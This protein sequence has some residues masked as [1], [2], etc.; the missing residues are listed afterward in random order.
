MLHNEFETINERRHL[1]MNNEVFIGAI[2]AGGSKIV[3]TVGR[4]W[5]EICDSEKY[6]VPTTTPDE[7][8]TRVLDWFEIRNREHTINAFGVATFGPVDFAT[9]SIGMTTPKKAWRGFSWQN[10]IDERFPALPIGY[11]TDTNAAGIAEWRWGI[12]KDRRVV[13]YVTVGTGIGG[14]L[15]IDG[16]PVHG[17]L[18]P[19]FGHMFVPRQDGDEFVGTCPA[20]GH[21][22]EG[23]ASG[24]AVNRRRQQNDSMNRWTISQWDLES[25]YLSLAMANVISVA[26]PEI[27]ILG[28][29]IMNVERL[30][31]KV[32][33][34][35]KELLSGYI[36]KEELG[37]RI[38]EYL[39]SPALGA[40]SGVVGAFALGFDAIH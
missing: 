21:C 8:I 9:K 39:V 28:G 17:L 15:I 12:A 31:Q 4:D 3:C 14:G 11:D 13:V 33:G 35:T 38:N 6:I 34:R 2:E 26:S 24:F 37:R 1:H 27:I 22:L 23:L 16:A 18:H 7:T 20:H 36:A 19:E 40:S 5:K 29:G 32:R 30:L 25:E 10:S